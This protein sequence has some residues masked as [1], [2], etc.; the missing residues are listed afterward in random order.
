MRWACS[1]K[2]AYM[3]CYPKQKTARERTSGGESNAEPGERRWGVKHNMPSIQSH[4]GLSS[5]I[6][7]QKEKREG[8]S[9]GLILMC[10]LF[11]SSLSVASRAS[12]H[13]PPLFLS[14]SSPSAEASARSTTNPPRQPESSIRSSPLAFFT[15]WKHGNTRKAADSPP[16]P[17]SAPCPSAFPSR[18]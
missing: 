15:S 9:L 4:L 17:C 1:R 10:A 7:I 5:R 8:G 18:R 13:G 6:I 14:I 12:D 16:L 11:C 3:F 2:I